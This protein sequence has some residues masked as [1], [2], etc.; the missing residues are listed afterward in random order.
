ML[1]EA[2]NGFVDDYDMKFRNYEP[3]SMEVDE[4]AIKESATVDVYSK[5]ITHTISPLNIGSNLEDLN[6]QIYTGL[7][8]QMIYGESFEEEPNM[9]L[10]QGWQWLPPLQAHPAVRENKDTWLN[11]G[12][13]AIEDGTFLMSGMRS[14]KTY[15]D[16]V[17]IREGIIECDMMQPIQS[18]GYHGTNLYFCNSDL[19]KRSYFVVF[20]PRKKMIELKRWTGNVYG[21]V[22]NTL[23]YASDMDIELGKWHNIKVAVKDGYIK[24]YL[25]GSSSPVINYKQTEQLE[26]GIGLDTCTARGAFRNL[27]VTTDKTTWK[28]DFVSPPY[29]HE[30]N[31]SRWWEPIVTGSVDAKFKWKLGDAYNTERSQVIMHKG[32]GG[33]VGVANRGLK[34]WGLFFEKGDKY[35]GRLYLK[36]DYSGTVTLALQNEDGSKTYASETLRGVGDDWKRFDF[37]MR[38]KGTTNDGRLAIWIDS[39]GIL[40]VDQVVMMPA[41]KLYKGLPVRAD[42]AESIKA[43]VSHMRFGGDMIGDLDFNWKT[44]YGDP[45]KRIQSLGPW[46]R[47]KSFGWAIFEYLQ[48]CEAAE[49]VPIPNI[50][51]GM[52][53]Q[54]CADFVE[55]CNGDKTTKWGRI[56]IAEHRKKPYNIKFLHYGNGVRGKDAALEAAQK[57]HKIDPSVKVMLGDVGG[58]IQY[59]MKPEQAKEYADALHGKIYAFGMRTDDFDLERHLVWQ[60]AVKE[61]K[62]RF[63]GDYPGVDTK[64]YIEEINAGRYNWQR[65]LANAVFINVAESYDFVEMLSFCNTA[66]ADKMMFAWDQGHI[67]FNNKN[68]WYQPCGWVLKLAKDYQQTN[69]IDIKVESPIVKFDKRRQPSLSVGATINDAG[70]ELVLKIVSQYPASL[71]TT[72]KLNDFDAN[73]QAEVVMLKG[74]LTDV[75]TAENPHNIAPSAFK[76]H[77]IAEE[78]TY[79]FPMYSYTIFKIKK[80]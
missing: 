37:S 33:T 22:G 52:S 19:D 48:F 75:N 47:R 3:G 17:T 30:T 9:E 77:G 58:E 57:I 20:W 40:A 76:F 53:P 54:D 45:D 14:A 68:A 2:D 16:D 27:K 69:R 61:Y 23:A 5:K 60:D 7:Y 8:A 41:D 44:K 64:L 18:P 63:M 36:G 73:N 12:C 39:P 13:F 42:I 21:M 11:W 34:K 43:M 66:Q 79:T 62:K 29:T 31:I 51:E 56:R 49:I 28:A 80:N 10:M 72:F 38:S 59:L 70:D 78:F 50:W 35:E 24:I 71:A 32:G 15:T 26:G 6:H 74:E 55:F 1:V 4:N 65:A 67:F 46:N 25:D